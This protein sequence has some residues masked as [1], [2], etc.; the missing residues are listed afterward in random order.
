MIATRWLANSKIFFYLALCRKY[1]PSPVLEK[2]RILHLSRI[3]K[4][5]EVNYRKCNAYD[6]VAG[7]FV[8]QH[9]RGCG[10]HGAGKENGKGN[11]KCCVL[12]AVD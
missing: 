3:A 1:L 7:L 8:L 11:Y 10:F 12:G 6:H 4:S 2:R 9:C 5:Q